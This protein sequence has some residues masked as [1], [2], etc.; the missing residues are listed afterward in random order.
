MPFIAMKS[1]PVRLFLLGSIA[2]LLAGTSVFAQTPTEQKPKKGPASK[3]YLAE[4]KGDS[5]I[6]NGGKIYTAQQATVFEAPGTVIET[7]QDA[8]DAIVYS[9]GTGMFVDQSTRVN[10]QRF[11]QGAFQANAATALTSVHEPSVSQSEVHVAYGAIGICT[12][13]LISGSSMVYVTPHASINIRGGKVSIE[14]TPQGTFVDLLEGDITIRS[15]EKDVGGQILRAGERA[16]IRPAADAGKESVITVEPIPHEQMP[17]ADRRVEMACHAR[18]SVTFEVIER[19]A[20]EGPQAT[21]PTEAV[22]D[23]AGD[24]AGNEA[25]GA[26]GTQQIVAQPTVPASTPNNI[27][28][29]P[30]RLPGT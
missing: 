6:Q 10:I 19:K 28:I 29:S 23:A 17:I 16:I 21:D 18:K 20:E 15:G 30:D 7:K 3:I 5:T 11:L 22:A 9:N 24:T 25:A 27:V 12:N 2:A 1:S 26:E 8:H 14:S 4:T 13:Q